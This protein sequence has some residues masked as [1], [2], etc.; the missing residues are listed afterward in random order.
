VGV[1][2]DYF[3]T[4]G[5]YFP[6]LDP[7]IPGKCGTAVATELADE[8]KSAITDF[9]PDS[10]FSLVGA[11]WKVTFSECEALLLQCYW[12]T[13]PAEPS[14]RLNGIVLRL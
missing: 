4:T 2:V 11:F 9:F 1:S 14:S 10:C 8:K 3:G 5:K 7:F 12:I 6:G 13:C